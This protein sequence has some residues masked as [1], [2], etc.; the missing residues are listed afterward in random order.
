[1]L[2]MRGSARRE[3]ERMARERICGSDL[4]SARTA[5]LEACALR[6]QLPRP[7]PSDRLI[8][9]GPPVPHGPHTPF[10]TAPTHHE[11][12]TTRP[13]VTHHMAPEPNSPITIRPL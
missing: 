11:N 5:A 7:S 1:M 8:P 12:R 10:H 6:H 3:R 4:G 13:P 2:M 9:H